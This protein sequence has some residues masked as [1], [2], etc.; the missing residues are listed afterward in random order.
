MA[1]GRQST[2]P[3]RSQQ[4]FALCAYSVSVVLG[5][6]LLLRFLVPKFS[7]LSERAPADTS[8]AQAAS[9][10]CCPDLL[11]E[12]AATVNESVDP[13]DDFVRYACGD[14]ERRIR[15]REYEDSW[16]HSQ[17]WLPALTGSAQDEASVLLRQVY[18]SCARN[19][20]RPMSAF[21][22]AAAAL[23]EALNLRN[24]DALSIPALIVKVT[25]SFRIKLFI[26]VSFMQARTAPSCNIVVSRKAA[27]DIDKEAFEYQGY[28][29]KVFG[30]RD[31][32]LNLTSM[33]LDVLDAMRGAPS[34]WDQ[35]VA[36]VKDGDA[37]YDTANASLHLSSQ[38]LWRGA[39]ALYGLWQPRM[40]ITIDETLLLQRLMQLFMV[41]W[42]D[43]SVI[44][45]FHMSTWS[46]V[47]DAI[48]DRY[49]LAFPGEWQDSCSREL[50]Q[51][52]Y[53]WAA[54]A[55]YR[56]TSG[57]SDL[58]VASFIDA[59]LGEVEAQVAYLFP[60]DPI[61]VER[62]LN[63][64]L[65]AELFPA[66]WSVPNVT[67]SYW[68][69]R[70][71]ISDW[72]TGVMLS[73][74][75]ADPHLLEKIAKGK[76]PPTTFFV[77]PTIYARVRDDVGERFIVNDALFGVDLATWVWE[78][79]LKSVASRNS[80]RASE[81][82]TCLKNTAQLN[83]TGQTALFLAIRSMLK[84]RGAVDWGGLYFSVGNLKPFSSSKFF[85]VVFLNQGM[86]KRALRGLEMQKNVRAY[87]HVL[88]NVE[89]FQQTFK[90]PPTGAISGY[91][92]QREGLV[93][94]LSDPF[95]LRYS[96]HS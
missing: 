91:C 55:A 46:L 74:E 76:P 4:G 81:F 11:Q 3:S 51:Y 36:A 34:D 54:A 78:F 90:C 9:D 65:P 88:R 49:T 63:F 23:H 57:A 38:M 96:N 86:C 66:D 13:C 15:R 82:T 2:T 61:S 14:I 8:G 39:L 31:S 52:H 85:Y 7:L 25:A 56:K 20:F 89:N 72:L 37:N 75:S 93:S 33:H 94:I 16:F 92:F 1:G 21:A 43:V 28:T 77:N 83:S 26:R 50:R 67:L 59:L 45:I 22:D 30:L 84:I 79:V 18:L 80:S 44:Y 60:D 17:L 70:L 40:H 5:T 42:Q 10:G 73:S 6:A 29:A 47:A 24:T 32:P 19:D 41:T 95:A 48:G 68:A 69:N 12:L 27:L 87:A 53:L 35:L 64:V 71:A 58:V 62:E